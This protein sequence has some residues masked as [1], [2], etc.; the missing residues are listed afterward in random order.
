M[1][2]YP[3]GIMI[4][5]VAGERKNIGYC[6]RNQLNKSKI[7]KQQYVQEEWYLLESKTHKCDKSLPGPFLATVYIV[8]IG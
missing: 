7:L 1:N 8:D 6:W 5:I 4:R 2:Q 3:F